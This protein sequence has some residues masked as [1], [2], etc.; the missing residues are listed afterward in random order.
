[1]EDLSLHIMDIMENSLRAGA[2]SV[3]LRIEENKADGILILEIGDD[4]AG[5]VRSVSDPFYT[6]KPNKRI[7]M[8]ISLLIQSCEETGGS[9]EI[10]S[11]MNK[12]TQIRAV[13]H[14]NNIDMRPLGDI[15]ETMRVMIA[16]HPEVN[17]N[18]EHLSDN[19]SSA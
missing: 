3:H 5:M 12:G 4:G 1:M 8:G 9:V 17:F 6:T 19:G 2:G 7:G 15:E 18:Y 13:F 14:T 10:K 16:T 11:D